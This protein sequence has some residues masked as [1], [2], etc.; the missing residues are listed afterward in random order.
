MTGLSTFVRWLRPSQV[1]I[2]PTSLMDGSMVYGV[3]IQSQQL[4]V[5]LVFSV[6]LVFQSHADSYSDYLH[7]FDALRFVYNK[8]I[9]F[10]ESIVITAT[11]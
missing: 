5:L 8:N 1:Q 9:Y 11:D 7:S 6:F 2:P 10:L 4:P 3:T